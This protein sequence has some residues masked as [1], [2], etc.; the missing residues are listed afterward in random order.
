LVEILSYFFASS[1]QQMAAAMSVHNTLTEEHP[2]WNTNAFYFDGQAMK[3]MFATQS[4]QFSMTSLDIKTAFENF[5]RNPFFNL[6]LGAKGNYVQSSNIF[7]VT[8][9]KQTATYALSAKE[10]YNFFVDLFIALSLPQFL[11]SEYAKRLV[12]DNIPD[13][14][15]IGFAGV[16]QLRNLHGSES[17]EYKIAIQILDS[18]LTK[19]FG[20]VSA[21]YSR[22][23]F[24]TVFF[25]QSTSAV[26]A[27]DV[28]PVV[29][30]H[31][32]SVPFEQLLPYIYLKEEDKQRSVQI[33]S[34]VKEAATNFDV[35]CLPSTTEHINLLRYIETFDL[36]NASTNSSTNNTIITPA[37]VAIF[38]ITLWFSIALGLVAI[39]AVYAISIMDVGKDSIIYRGGPQLQNPAQPL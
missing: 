8:L 18:V 19:L 20:E 26:I 1:D 31:I 39:A 12:S 25:L 35:Y 37:Q 30:S 15:S 29:E 36:G 23:I 4:G 33:C 16:E 17:P 28:L 10:D 32:V 7:Q 24:A 22:R 14:L 38:Q 6:P 34:N 2:Y 21:L 3:N 13:L 9:D 27:P 11:H 5:N